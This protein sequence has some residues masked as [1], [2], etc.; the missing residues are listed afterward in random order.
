[1]IKRILCCLTILSASFLLAI[2]ISAQSSHQYPYLVIQYGNGELLTFRLTDNIEFEVS[3]NELHLSGSSEKTLGTNDIQSLGIAYGDGSFDLVF[4]PSESWSIYRL[5]GSPVDSG[6]NGT[7]N[8]GKPSPNVVYIIN[9]GNQRY[10]F[11]II[12]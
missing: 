5:D 8:L 4:E 12:K 7:P 10:K 1:M 3:A 9:Q 6:T 2:N 11:V